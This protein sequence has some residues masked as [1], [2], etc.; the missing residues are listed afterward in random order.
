MQ[1][2]IIDQHPVEQTA[3]RREI[4]GHGY[5]KIRLYKFLAVTSKEQVLDKGIRQ[6][7]KKSELVHC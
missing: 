4:K 5:I 6:K 3:Y 2:P 7:S 1:Q